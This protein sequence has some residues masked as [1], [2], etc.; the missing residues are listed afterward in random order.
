MWY[1]SRRWLCSNHSSAIFSITNHVLDVMKIFAWL[2][3]EGGGAM[4]L[5]LNPIYQPKF[6]E[7]VGNLTVLKE[8]LCCKIPQEL[9]L[10][11][12]IPTYK[13]R[14]IWQL[15]C[16]GR[17]K[18]DIRESIEQI[19]HKAEIAW[20]ASILCLPRASKWSGLSSSLPSSPSDSSENLL[21]RAFKASP[22]TEG[23]PLAV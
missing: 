19:S 2:T 1:Q 5:N 17:M 15:T 16:K 22:L 20:L 11:I 8:V 23:Q 7:W 10:A 3:C 9:N 4:Q 6:L 18:L 21:A 14:R 12:Q 13:M